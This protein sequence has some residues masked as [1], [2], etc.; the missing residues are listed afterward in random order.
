MDLEKPRVRFE[1]GGQAPRWPAPLH[2]GQ[3]VPNDLLS[4]APGCP[5]SKDSFLLVSGCIVA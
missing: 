4:C 3:P 2:R 1:G 5:E